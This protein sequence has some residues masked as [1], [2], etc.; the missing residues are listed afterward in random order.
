MNELDLGPG[1][2]EP[3]CGWPWVNRHLN[4]P[5]PEPHIELITP[6]SRC[7]MTIKKPGV[8]KEVAKVMSGG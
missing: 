6:T 8:M 3:L 5:Y 4:D 2:R 1:I 7:S